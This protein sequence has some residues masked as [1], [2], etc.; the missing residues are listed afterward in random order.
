[1]NKKLLVVFAIGVVAYI[2]FKKMKED[3][4]QKSSEPE[5]TP[6]EILEEAKK[7]TAGRGGSI[8]T[9][10]TQTTQTSS[11]SIVNPKLATVGRGIVKTG[12]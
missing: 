9:Q 11:K 12:R 7:G 6:E 10:T 1:M 8:P 2:V 3:S 5:K 4:A